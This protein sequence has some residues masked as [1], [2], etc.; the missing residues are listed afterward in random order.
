MHVQKRPAPEKQEPS[1]STERTVD[2]ELVRRWG[3]EIRARRQ[4][5]EAFELRGWH[6]AV[7]GL[8]SNPASTAS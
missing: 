7:E 2:R 1:G 6:L 3:A 5:A 8:G 4:E